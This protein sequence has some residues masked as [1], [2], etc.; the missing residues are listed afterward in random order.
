MKSY[1]RRGLLIILSSP[2]GAGKTTLS[3]MLKEWDSSIKE[4]V[5]YTTREPRPGE[6]DGREY[7]FVGKD[8]FL[9]LAGEGRFLEHAEVFGHHYGTPEGPVR[10]AVEAGRDVVFDIDWQGGAQIRQSD[11]EDDTISIFV[12]PPTIAALE[13]RLQKRDRGN[14]KSV[15][16]R[17]ATARK[18]ISHWAD[19]DFVL[20]NKNLDRVFEKVCSIIRSERTR[21]S[22]QLCLGTFVDGLNREFEDRKS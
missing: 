19:Y 11:L 21:R 20:V 9:S 4:S 13:C 6:K 18:E 7:H 8:R 2:S 16:Y 12:L 17:M 3:R 14:E 5:S 15:A 1:R 22:R 10:E